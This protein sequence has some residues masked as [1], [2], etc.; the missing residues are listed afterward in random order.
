MYFLM[1]CLVLVATAADDVFRRDI[2]FPQELR[3]MLALI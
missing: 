3:V 1:L 2:H